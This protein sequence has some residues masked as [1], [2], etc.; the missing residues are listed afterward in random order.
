MWTKESVDNALKT[1]IDDKA[2]ML[3]LAIE[4][5]E[6]TRRF[7]I[8]VNNLAGDEAGPKAQ[9]ITD[10]PHGT[11]VT[12]PTEQIAIKVASGWLPPEIKEMRNELRN[13]QAEYNIAS[14]RVKYVDVWLGALSDREH[15]IILHQVMQGEY[16]R[17][18]IMDYGK[19]FGGY[20][21]KDSLKFLRARAYKRIYAVAKIKN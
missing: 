4:I 6:L 10:M 14:E 13:L 11:G 16:W 12:N 17:D 8:A 21:T 9:V 3:H 2:R 15:W 18:V 1:Y 19:Q 5:A 20:V 7:N